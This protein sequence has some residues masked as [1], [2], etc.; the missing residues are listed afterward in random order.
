MK[1]KVFT[2]K[3]LFSK[4]TVATLNEEEMNSVFAGVKTDIGD[5]CITDAVCCPNGVP[6]ATYFC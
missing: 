2:K 3:L 1:K 4:E 6:P 5:T